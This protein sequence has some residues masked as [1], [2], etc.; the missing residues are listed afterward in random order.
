MKFSRIFSSELSLKKKVKKSKFLKRTWD[1]QVYSHLNRVQNFTKVKKYEFLKLTWDSHVSSH[2]NR[3]LEFEF[4]KNKKIQVPK[5]HVSFSHIFSSESSLKNKVK[6]VQ[7]PKTQERSPGVFLSE[8]SSKF[9]KRLKIGVPKTHVR[10]SCA[11]HLI[12]VQNITNVRK[13]EFLNLT[14][15]S[16]VS[17]HL[18]RVLELEFNKIKKYKYVKLT[19]VSRTYSHLNQA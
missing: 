3:V 4:K 19:W 9:Y 16:Q 1:S 15:D 10:F 7:L 12:R 6:K 5:T 17:S 14:W 11:S 2:L 8:S 18:N 13:Y